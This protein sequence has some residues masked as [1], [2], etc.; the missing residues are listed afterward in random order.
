MDAALSLQSLQLQQYD[1][2]LTILYDLFMQSLE[3]TITHFVPS[4]VKSDTCNVT[5]L[6]FKNVLRK[7]TWIVKLL[8]QQSK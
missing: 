1:N 7:R 2:Y 6:R 8:R 4:R 5:K 3:L